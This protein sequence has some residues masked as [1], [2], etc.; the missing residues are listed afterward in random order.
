MTY[1]GDRRM[2]QMLAHF[3]TTLGP[4]IFAVAPA[5]GGAGDIPV[6]VS[7]VGTAFGADAVVAVSGTLVAIT[8][9]VV[10]S[11]TLITATFTIDA[12]AAQTA[13]TVTVTTKGVVAGPA[14][15]TVTAPV[16]LPGSTLEMWVDATRNQDLTIATGVSAWRDGNLNG[17]VLAQAT[18][19]FQPLKVPNVIN[20][21]QIVRFDGIGDYLELDA[22]SA[23]MKNGFTVFIVASVPFA[24]T[25]KYQPLFGAW[26]EVS[27]QHE[28]SND[29]NVPSRSRLEGLVATN[30][31][32]LRATPAGVTAPGARVLTLRVAPSEPS[33]T[34]YKNGVVDGGPT[35]GFASIGSTIGT[36]IRFVSD[37]SGV[38]WGQYDIGEMWIYSSA[39]AAT[40]RAA[41]EAY[42]IRKWI[43][44]PTT[45]RGP[46][47]LNSSVI[48]GATVTVDG[49]GDGAG[50]WRAVPGRSPL[51]GNTLLVTFST[52]IIQFAMTGIANTGF[53]A[54]WGG[55]PP[56][57]FSGELAYLPS[58]TQA[59]TSLPTAAPGP[60]VIT[61]TPGFSYVFIADVSA[62]ETSNMRFWLVGDPL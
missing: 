35:A 47:L 50:N 37:F 11:A 22:W 49:L 44:V 31:G 33:I 18:A 25:T 14:A 29:A 4:T 61:Y 5:V 59:A 2:V 26:G 38:N 3:G 16:N 45:G 57:T 32:L 30:A 41:V 9:V 58:P 17:R 54:L 24:N 10:V 1:F 8:N 12:A 20:G 55:G 36:A 28:A 42:L 60:V 39:L 23:E 27:I 62:A 53:S 56:A 48:G 19:G 6:N 40:P 46:I 15:F 21:L 51:F 13:R 52:P 34:L 7:I 43:N